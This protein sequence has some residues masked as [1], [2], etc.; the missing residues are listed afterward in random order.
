LKLAFDDGPSR[1]TVF[2]D[3]DEITSL[4]I[5]QDAPD[6]LC[7]WSLI[8]GLLRDFPYELHW[9]MGMIVGSADLIPHLP[10]NYIKTLGEPL[11]TTD[12]ITIRD[13]VARRRVTAPSRG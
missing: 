6:Y 10:V 4:M 13:D 5:I 11:V 12:P 3:D 9:P 2:L 7:F 1:T 8:A